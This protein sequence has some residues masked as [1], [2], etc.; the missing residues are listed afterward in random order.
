MEARNVVSRRE[1]LIRSGTVLGGLVLLKGVD[2]ATADVPGAT[3]P[4]EETA[5]DTGRPEGART[6][7]PLGE[8]GRDYTPVVTPN[9]STLPWKVVDGAKVYHLVAEPVRREFAPGL[10]VNCW[11][12]NG[13]TPGPTIEAVEGD[14]VRIFVTN[15][16]P[17]PTS[18]HWH[19]VLLPNGM[20]GVSGLNQRAIQP[21]ETY[22]YE[23]TLR[24]HGTFMYH[25]HFDEMVQMGMGM[26]GMFIMHPRNPDGPK[27]DRDFAIMLSEWA[28]PPGAAT[29]NTTVMTDFNMLTFNGK[30]YPATAPLVA[31]LGDHVRLRFGNLSANNHHPIHLHGYRFRV[32]A[33]DGGRIP[34]AGQWPE[35]TVLVPV[36]STRDVEF[37][38]DALGDWA[39]HCHMTHH[40]MNQM[41]HNV[42]NMLG[43]KPGKAADNIRKVL[44]DYTTMGQTGMGDMAEMSTMM[45]VPPNSIP[46]LGGKGPFGSIDMGGM[47]TVF[48]V[49]DGLA[50]Y[51]DPG[52]Y[53]YP[54][55]TLASRATAAELRA[56]G[57]KVNG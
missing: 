45:S 2:N 31:R 36:G 40:T 47:F 16:L 27:F 48:K 25:P 56:A 38:A 6:A 9:G 22:K 41:G 39:L 37:S 52:F 43:V 34:E 30:A 20:D 1:M 46:M 35:T 17:E 51:D 42:P 10:L 53:E 4:P 5:T 50:N 8:P 49:R 3:H 12:Y 26:H 18:V 21:G 14:R 29:P 19:G 28:I 11:G 54:P 15:K 23:F 44:P 7:P 33:T 13:E 57:I 32:T 24:Q 55:G